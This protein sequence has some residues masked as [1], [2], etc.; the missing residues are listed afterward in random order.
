MQVK[1][2]Y[3]PRGYLT[4]ISLITNNETYGPFGN[5]RGQHFQSLPHGVLGFCG[6]SGRVVDQLGVL[7]YV[8]NPWNSHLDKKVLDCVDTLQFC[9]FQGC[10]LMKAMR[11]I[12]CITE[13]LE[14]VCMKCSLHALKSRR[15]S[16]GHG[17]APADKISMMEEVTS[18]RF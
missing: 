7:T 2:T 18:W 17:E 14:C 10:L 8:E 15:L 5:S 13:A 6:R 12:G 16:T 1:G 9:E 11:S 3:D 4:S